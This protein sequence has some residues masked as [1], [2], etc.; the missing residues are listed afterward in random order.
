MRHI[1]LW[2]PPGKWN[3]VEVNVDA[4]GKVRIWRDGKELESRPLSEL[5]PP[6][7]YAY[8]EP[9]PLSELEPPRELPNVIIHFDPDIPSD[10]DR[11]E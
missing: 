8:M 2:T 9:R 1:R 5:E 3:C 6:A 7:D 10:G 4:E 11:H